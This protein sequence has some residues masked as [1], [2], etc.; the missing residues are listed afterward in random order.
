M[1]RTYRRQPAVPHGRPRASHTRHGSSVRAPGLIAHYGAIQLHTDARLT[2]T[3]NLNLRGSD[4]PQLQEGRG[5][6]VSD[7]APG[8]WVALFSAFCLAG[9]I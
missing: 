1:F 7:K 3:V 2:N 8:V 6:L 5:E 4:L 9:D